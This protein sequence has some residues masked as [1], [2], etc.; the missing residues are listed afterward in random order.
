[1]AGTVSAKTVR[2]ALG[3][4]QGMGLDARALAERHGVAD[5]LTDVDARFPHPAY[6]G[7]WEELERRADGA[8]V[9]I[10]AAERLPF[11]H[12]DVVDYLLGTSETLE[13]G[14]RRFER[15]FAIIS[16][17]VTHTL[18][19]HGDEVHL[20]RRYAAAAQMRLLAPAEF[21]FAATLSHVR[22]ALGHPYAPREVRFA[23]PAPASDAEHRRFFGCP[24]SFGA[25]LSAIVLD[26]A[27]LALPMQRPEPELALIL[28]RHA[29]LLVGKVG[30]P[31]ED[32]PTRVRRVVVEGLPDGNVSLEWTARR[33]AT[34]VRTLQRRLREEGLSYDALL[35]GTRRDLARQ[36]LGDPALSIQETAHLLAFGDLRGFYRAFRRWEGRTPAEYRQARGATG[37]ASGAS[38]P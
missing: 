21:A 5:A 1:M 27:A 7:V 4:A 25:A 9:G 13:V 34:S 2:A 17:G 23:A 10:R 31:D 19:E 18:E 29:E 8:A 16:T 35:D 24:V 22:M 37:A 3:V 12:W 32:F 26:R 28:E 15:Y 20:V 36:Y 14:L 38:R 30:S 11:G 33:L 6:I